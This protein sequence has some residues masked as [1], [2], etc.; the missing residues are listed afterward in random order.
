MKQN[1]APYAALVES[2]D[3]NITFDSIYTPS[4]GD[5]VYVRDDGGVG[6]AAIARAD[7]YVAGNDAC[8]AVGV[9][10]DTN[11]YVRTKGINFSSFSSVKITSTSLAF[12]FI[13][14]ATIPIFSLPAI[15]SLPIKS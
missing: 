14:S 3:E 15:T 6:K 4:T 9:A 2:V 12:D 8:V 10:T 7:A 5:V 1:Y 13:M 11:N